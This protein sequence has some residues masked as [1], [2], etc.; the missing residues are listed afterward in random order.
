MKVLAVGDLIGT[1]G[2][3][4]LEKE[5]K[6]IK[7]DENIDFCIVNAENVA[8]GMGITEKAF[9]ALLKLNVDCITMGNHTWAK[10]RYIQFYR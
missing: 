7:D 8:E 9:Q 2:L 1:A 3:K 5:Y 6:R 10:K 4:K